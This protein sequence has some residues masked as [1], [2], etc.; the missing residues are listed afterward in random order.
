MN[1]Y[2]VFMEKRKL[3]I[4]GAGIAGLTAAHYAAKQGFEVEVFEAT[5]NAGGRC[6]SYFDDKLG[7][8]IDN[9]NH[10]IMG[11]NK[12][13]LRLIKDLGIENRLNKFDDKT[14]T[15]F[16]NR[17]GE[18]YYYH[19][20]F[21][22][23]EKFGVLNFVNLFKFILLPTAKPVREAFRL[24]PNIYHKIINPVSR[25]ILNTPS[26]AAN[27]NILRRVF[28]KLITSRSGFDHYYPKNNWADALITPLTAALQAAG[29]KMNYNNSLKRTENSDNI[30]QKLIFDDR[31]IDVEND[32]VVLA[33][34][35]S[36][37]SK[38][39]DIET[40]DEFSAIIN[41]HFKFPHNFPPQIIGV[42][43]SNIEWIFVKP[44]M[45]STTYSAATISMNDADLARNTWA[46]CSRVL[47]ISQNMP[48]HRILT[49]KRAT[50]ACTTQQ[51]KKR[52]EQ[53]TK[54]TNLFLAGDYVKNGLPA[55]IEGAVVSGKKVCKYLE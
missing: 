11:A 49:E 8:V 10:L 45:I 18:R 22:D 51:L 41:V 44:D 42:I 3:Y 50:F 46:I 40:P 30:I 4:I 43:N 21:P 27:S 36:S 34:P 14:F 52:P 26:E 6:R 15:F 53:R 13:I 24:S 7:T 20:P 29:V 54:Y 39:V 37:V 1:W 19:A 5:A 2:N 55:T 33:T 35:P 31:E 23:L 38:L 47:G 48:E 12:N 25:S 28:I 17:N 9:G 16:D 32:M